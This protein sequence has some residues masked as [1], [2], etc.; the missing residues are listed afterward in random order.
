VFLNKKFLMNSQKLKFIFSI[1]LITG[2]IY[3]GWPQIWNFPPEI[4]KAHAAISW[5]S[6]TCANSRDGNGDMTLTL[7]TTQENDLVIITY[8]IGDADGLEFDMDAAGFLSGVGFTEIVDTTVNSADANEIDLGVYWKIMGATP[9]TSVTIDGQGGNDTSVPAVCMVFRGVDTTNPMDVIPVSTQGSDTMH[10]NPP[11]I[12]HN[13]PSGIWTV[14]AGASGHNIGSGTF[15]FP[16]GYTT[17]PVY[18]THADTSD[19][20]VGMG[21]RLSGVSDPEDPG[22]MT[23]SGTD[24]TGY[25]W[26]AATIALRPATNAVPTIT[27]SNPPVGNTAVA[28]GA[29]Y[30]IQYDLADTD[31][32]ATADFYYET[33]GNGTGG[34]AIA[35][36]QNQAEGT[37]TTCVFA[38]LSESMSVSTAYYIYGIA[39][40]GV[41]PDVMDVSS[42]TITVNDAPTLTVSQPDG[43]SDTVTV[44]DVYNITYT[45]SDTDDIVTVDFY[46]DSDAT[47]LDGTVITNC[48]DKIE[49]TDITC[50]WDTTGMSAGSYYVYGRGVSDG[51]NSEVSD[52]SS[53]QI[54][55]NAANAA[56]TVSAVTL[57]SGGAI[58]LTENTSS[59]ISLVGT[60]TDTNG[61]ADI[62]YAT[63]VI[64]RSGVGASCSED[65]NNCYRIASGNCAKS[66]CSGNTCDFSCSVNIQYFADPTDTGTFGGQTWAGQMTV[67]DIAGETGSSTSSGVTLNSLY[68]LIV[69]GAINFG[70]INPDEDTGSVTQTTTVTNTG[71]AAID[72][73][74]SGAAM[75]NGGA[76]IEASNQKY[77]TSTFTY[78]SCDTPTCTAL[79]GTPTR[80]ETDLAKP[81]SETSVTDEIFWGLLV[82]LGRPSGSYSGTNTFEALA[83]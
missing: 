63:S 29:N 68:A 44:G 46:Y 64:Y 45:L 75:T 2:W 60:G 24:N 8:A 15:T 12:N 30:T 76:S 7:P 78:S 69:T 26:A 50:A 51:V 48:Q 6:S 83:D 67:G 20:T 65:Q 57:N 58:N 31:S 32:V 81:T 34:T 35:A 36:C 77:A 13:N 19:A 82:P 52:Y 56:P 5:V 18:R 72:V 62:S 42:G 61:N 74:L 28:D 1:I 43:T 59:T 27:V 49:G 47:G 41:N 14:I 25:S 33:D 17:N 16:T 55:I 70:S 11:S 38:P 54:T 79:S 3:S 80:L 23:H 22:V 73:N 9:D 39:S 37:N 71:N 10:P 40:D 21:Y 53:G 4:Y 66:N